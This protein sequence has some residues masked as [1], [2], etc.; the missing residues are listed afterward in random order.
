MPSLRLTPPDAAVL[1]SIIETDG[2]VNAA[3]EEGA[4]ATLPPNNE[5]R[6]MNGGALPAF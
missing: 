1:T 2:D 3:A 4:G 6:L 5:Q